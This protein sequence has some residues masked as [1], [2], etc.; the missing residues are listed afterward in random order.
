MEPAWPHLQIVYEFFLKFIASSETDAKIAKR[1]VDH[2][3]YS[4]S[5]RPLLTRGPKEREHLKTI[6]HA[7]M[8]SSWCTG[9]SSE[10][11][12]TIYSTDSF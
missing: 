6:L 9:P 5:A 1:Y 10:K 11:A 3:F 4:P 8:E 12:L 2:S 7:S